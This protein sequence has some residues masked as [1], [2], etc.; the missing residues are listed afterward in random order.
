MRVQ[1]CLA[2]E[3]DNDGFIEWLAKIMSRSGENLSGLNEKAWESSAGVAPLH[4]YTLPKHN[5][6]H[7]YFPN[8]GLVTISNLWQAAEIYRWKGVTLQATGERLVQLA[9]QLRASYP[10]SVGRCVEAAEEVLRWGG[11]YR[12]NGPWIT[13]NPQQLIRSMQTV[14]KLHRAGTWPLQGG[15]PR[16]R[17]NSG[18][19]KIYA[20]Q[21]PGFIIYDSRV[22]A[23]LALLALIYRANNDNKMPPIARD[24]RVMAGRAGHRTPQAIKVCAGESDHLR[25]NLAANWLIGQVFARHPQLRA[26]WREHTVGVDEYRAL[27][28]ALFMVGYDIGTHAVLDNLG[29]RPLHFRDLDVTPIRSV[30]SGVEIVGATTPFIPLRTAANG[31][32]FKA[33]RTVS[34]YQLHF[35]GNSGSAIVQTATLQQVA[36]HFAGQRVAI[37]ASR[38]SPP[39]GSLGEY[40]QRH[41]SKLGLA[42]YVAPLLVHLGLADLDG[43][44]YLVFVDEIK[45]DV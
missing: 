3:L 6:D 15:L 22:A 5:P 41:V 40:L 34:G 21:L 33:C 24:L 44:R 25:A 2:Y 19:T 12:N 10:D 23:A 1:Q 32:E 7:R 27:E 38:T 29:G 42:S 13:A 45:G 16:A 28:A 43:S 4:Q 18:F 31:V 26:D 35:G 9:A 37:G 11:V 17:M 14:A 8:R 20:L 39:E 36:H 30:K